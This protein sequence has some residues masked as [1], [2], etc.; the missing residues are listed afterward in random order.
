MHHVVQPCHVSKAQRKDFFDEVYS[1]KVGSC[2]VLT[3]QLLHFC[4]SQ[5]MVRDIAV[6][7][8]GAC[9]DCSQ[10]GEECDRWM[11]VVPWGLQFCGLLVAGSSYN[12]MKE[13]RHSIHFGSG[14]IFE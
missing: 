12:R 2:I 3:G 6:R 14:M 13:I 4:N 11:T 1:F 10:G 7:T 5:P 8:V 9:C